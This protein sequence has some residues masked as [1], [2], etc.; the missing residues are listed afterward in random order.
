M[1]DIAAWL[2]AAATLNYVSSNLPM[3]CKK[4]QQVLTQSTVSSP[5]EWVNIVHA[6]AVLSYLENDMLSSVLN[7]KFIEDIS[8]Y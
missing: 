8:N 6:F 4:A 3:F 2:Q 7:P 5:T 1:F